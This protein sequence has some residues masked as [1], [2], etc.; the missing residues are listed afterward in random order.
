M[1]KEQP[2][3]KC[4]VQWDKFFKFY[5]KFLSEIPVQYLI[6]EYGI[7][8]YIYINSVYIFNLRS[9]HNILYKNNGV[10]NAIFI[11]DSSV[12]SSRAAGASQ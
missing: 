3:Q 5:F 6:T 11:I 7:Y 12:K 8:I 1:H 2:Q 4:L 9:I 10:T